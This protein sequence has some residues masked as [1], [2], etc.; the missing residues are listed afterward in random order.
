MA[1]KKEE[2]NQ[3]EPTAR[4]IIPLLLQFLAVFVIEIIQAEILQR[5]LSHSTV[6]KIGLGRNRQL[7]AG[8]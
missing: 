7:C 1:T 4:L 2:S 5:A 3:V 8:A 6:Q